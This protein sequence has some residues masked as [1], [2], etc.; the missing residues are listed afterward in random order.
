[1]PDR[2]ADAVRAR[3]SE[4]RAERLLLDGA[5]R[6]ELR[7][8]LALSRI[9][10]SAAATT[11]LTELAREARLHVEG[12]DREGRARLPASL[13]AALDAVAVMVHARWVAELAPALRRIATGRSLVTDRDWPR[14]PGPR[15]PVVVVPSAPDPVRQAR[16]LLVG[17]A[18][19]VALWRLVLLPLAVLPLLGLPALGGPALAPFAAGVAVAGVVVAVRSRRATLE[20]AGLR[21]C[22][23]ETLTAGR[24]VVEADLGRRLLELERAVGAELDV[25]VARRRAVVEAELRVL[26]SDQPAAVSGG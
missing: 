13:A 10:A 22:V 16:T 12:A 3:R 24:A 8:E 7:S 19:G 21:R 4:L 26:A 5:H 25:A 11:A 20:R 9:A 15:L 2:Y 14:L 17:A 1:M 18:D 6:G 23:D